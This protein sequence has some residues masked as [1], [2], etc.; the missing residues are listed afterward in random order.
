MSQAILLQVQ[1]FL[2]LPTHSTSSRRAEND[3]SFEK[4]CLSLRK[5]SGSDEYYLLATFSNKFRDIDRFAAPHKGGEIVASYAHEAYMKFLDEHPDLAPHLWSLHIPGTARKNRAHWWDF[6]G[7]FCYA[8]FLLTKEEAE[9]VAAFSQEY[10]PGLSH[11]FFVF[12]YDKEQAVIEDYYTYEISIVPL[13]WAANPWTTFE[14]IA[15][16]LKMKLTPERRAALVKLHGEEYVKNLETKGDQMLAFL[17]EID[18]ESKAL[19]EKEKSAEGGNGKGNPPGGALR[20]AQ[21]AEAG[22]V[23]GEYAKSTDVVEALKAL[24]NDQLAKLK[25]ITERIDK[26]EGAAGE[27]FQEL[28]ERLENVEMP[29]SE[30]IAAKA[31][32][33]P[34]SLLTSWM[35]SSVV[36]KDGARVEAGSKLDKSAPQESKDGFAHAFAQMFEAEV[37]RG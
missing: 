11:G 1:K 23:E 28:E 35:P 9:G 10:T 27:K 36:G 19:A 34:L 26:I 6:D 15:K 29:D 7:V 14:T 18:V 37:N 24:Y 3:L 32:A 8:E 16:E 4:G 30:R 22:S 31:A 12:K 21:G 17:Q 13:E 20:Q 33:T 5:K 25:E 2:G